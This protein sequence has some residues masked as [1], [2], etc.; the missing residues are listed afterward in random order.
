MTKLLNQETAQLDHAGVCPKC[1]VSWDG[2][3]IFERMRAL[4]IMGEPYY[5]SKTAEEL[6]DC[7]RDY[8]WTPENKKRFSKLIGVEL[9]HDH[10]DHYDGVS[11][12]RC[13]ACEHQW[14]VFETAMPP[15]S[16]QV[17]NGL[18][19]RERQIGDELRTQTAAFLSSCQDLLLAA[20]HE[21]VRS[22]KRKVKF[23]PDDML[24][25]MHALEL[26]LLY[27]PGNIG[28]EFTKSLRRIA[29]KLTKAWGFRVV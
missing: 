24:A 8:G 6:R 23:S 10:P 17:D 15:A 19:D 28:K 4:Q 1:H 22:E 14:P 20:T 18:R 21:V 12:W 7:A 25:L 29:R 5:G 9:P 3:D 27:T 26:A 11:F 13:P 16:P 2:G